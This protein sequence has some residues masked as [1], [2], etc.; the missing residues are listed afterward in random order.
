MSDVQNV[1]VVQNQLHFVRKLICM[2]KCPTVDFSE[3]KFAQFAR[4]E[5]MSS[6][7]FTICELGRVSCRIYAEEIVK[8]YILLLNNHLVQKWDHSQM[9]TPIHPSCT[10]VVLVLPQ[11]D[12]SS[13]S[14]SVAG[15]GGAL[16][17]AAR[18][19]SKQ[20][21]VISRSSTVDW[22][23]ICRDGK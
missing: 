3:E 21:P 7:S 15:A 12:R 19:A 23:S 14:Q 9:M 22:R 10:S 5:V 6:E 20:I 8:E 18:S 4:Y 1:R 2:Q 17:N 13:V 16:P 11:P